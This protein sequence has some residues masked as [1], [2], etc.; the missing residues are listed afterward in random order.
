[1]PGFGAPARRG[2]V[3]RM[4]R[5]PRRTRA[6]VSR[7]GGAGRSQGRRRS[8]ASGRARRSW[9]WQ[10]M[11]SQVH[12]S[13]AAGS[14]ILGVVQ[15][16]VCLSGRCV[17]GASQTAYVGVSGH[18]PLIG[19]DGLLAAVVCVRRLREAR[20]GQ[21]EGGGSPC[22]Q[23]QRCPPVDGP[24]GRGSGLGGVSG[25]EPGAGGLSAGPA[26][27]ADDGLESWSGWRGWA[28]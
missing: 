23:M 14:R 1:L 2:M 19:I 10:V 28:G 24:V 5:N 7:P 3:A 13:A 17:K 6:G 18:A 22:L 26:G 12:R 15:P 4:F 16:R 9:V 25:G 27:R 21:S 8:S 11:M 20:A